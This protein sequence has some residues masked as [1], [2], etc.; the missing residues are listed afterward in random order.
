MLGLR[1]GRG[2][3]GEHGVE[4]QENGLEV[5]SPIDVERRYASEGAGGKVRVITSKTVKLRKGLG[6]G[7]VR[8]CI[9]VSQGFFSS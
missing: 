6:V 2:A 4:G 7:F 1:V 8:I 5:A 3:C 9:H